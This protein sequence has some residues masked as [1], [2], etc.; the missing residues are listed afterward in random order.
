VTAVF[1]DTFYWVTLAMPRE[2][3]HTRALSFTGYIITTE[4]VLGEYLTFFASAPDYVRR[5]ISLS[6]YDILADPGIR[7]VPQSHATFMAG[8]DFYSARLD[9]GY[10]MVDCISM[11]IMR[12]EGLTDVLTN[13]KHLEQDGFR[14]LF[15]S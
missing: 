6:V 10:S 9:K 5:E 8:L 4:E 14:A 12:R 15:R 7:V 11:A 2:V 13:D 1:A 3:A